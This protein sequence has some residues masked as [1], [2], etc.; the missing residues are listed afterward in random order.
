MYNVGMAQN[1]K[2]R[3]SKPRGQYV[4]VVRVPLSRAQKE[5]LKQMCAAD[6]RDRFTDFMRILLDDEWDRRQKT[7]PPA[8]GAAA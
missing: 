5:K 3:K 1:G 6:R 8:P 2:P 7:A 4:E